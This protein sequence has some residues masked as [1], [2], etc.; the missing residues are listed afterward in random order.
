M[1]P[2]KRP[3]RFRANPWDLG[4]LQ[5]RDRSGPAPLFE[6]SAG[7]PIDEFLDDLGHGACDP[8]EL[9]KPTFRGE[10]L[11]WMRMSGDGQRQ[12]RIPARVNLVVTADDQEVV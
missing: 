3:G 12:S 8:G 5:Y 11:Y 10:L 9:L 7:A 1:F 2:V 4:Q 6:L